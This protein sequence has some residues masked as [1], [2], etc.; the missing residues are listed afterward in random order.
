MFDSTNNVVAMKRDKLVVVSGLDDYIIADSDDVLLI[1]PKSEEQKI[2]VY[3]NEVKL[4]Y[5]D[6]YL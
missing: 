4:N 5:G 1:V 3:V 6:E 2:K